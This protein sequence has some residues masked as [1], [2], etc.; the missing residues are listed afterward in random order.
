MLRGLLPYPT[1]RVVCHVRYCCMVGP[2]SCAPTSRCDVRYWQRVCC[3]ALA[4]SSP[5]LTGHNVR[6]AGISTQ[7]SCPLS[8]RH[9]LTGSKCLSSREPFSRYPRS[10]RML[11]ATCCLLLAACYLL[12]AA[13]YLLYAMS[14]DAEM[15]E[16]APQIF[17][18]KPTYKQTY[19]QLMLAG[20]MPYAFPSLTNQIRK[21]KIRHKSSHS[22]V[23]F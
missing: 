22:C 19:R 9:S 18:R 4:M 13:C 8:C 16:R 21:T 6:A 14:G 12:L 11:L 1:V 10:S 15:G 23:F 2:G 20:R 3:Y 17:P 7:S 5:G